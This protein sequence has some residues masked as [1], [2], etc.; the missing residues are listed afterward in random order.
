MLLLLFYVSRATLKGGMKDGICKV[1]L[2]LAN[3]VF[4]A[5]VA[6]RHLPLLFGLV[7]LNYGI[8]LSLKKVVHRRLLLTLGI[9]T[10][11]VVLAFYKYFNFFGEQLDVYDAGKPIANFEVTWPENGNRVDAVY[12]IVGEHVYDTARQQNGSYL[13][14]ATTSALEEKTEVTV[15]GIDAEHGIRYQSICPLTRV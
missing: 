11:V 14:G 2:L 10:N 7:A 3:I 6:W 15:V 12:V 4:Y 9:V 5:W 1:L 13:W 8:A